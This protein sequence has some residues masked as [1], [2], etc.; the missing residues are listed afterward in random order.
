M[1][2]HVSSWKPG[3]L[4]PTKNETSDVPVLAPGVDLEER[5]AQL[6]REVL[7]GSGNLE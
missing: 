2:T 6:L 5:D 3:G 1:E 4:G 7:F